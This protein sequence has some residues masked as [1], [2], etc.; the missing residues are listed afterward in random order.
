MSSGAAIDSVNRRTMSPVVAD[1]GWRDDLHESE[2]RRSA[3]SSSASRA[4]ASSTSASA[5]AGPSRGCAR[6]APTT[7]ASTTCPR[8]SP[9]AAAFS[10]RPVRAG[11]CA[12]HAA[13]RRRVVRPHRLLVQ[14]HLHGR[15]H[16]SPR[17]PA[18]G[19]APARARRHFVFSTSNRND[20]DAG[21]FLWP[22][23]KMTT[24]PVRLAVR[25][26]VSSARGLSP[27]T[28]G[29]S[30]RPRSEPTTTPS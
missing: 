16:R 22:D 24:N 29:G 21:R 11:R 2:L 12:R 18:R 17:H 13:V 25:R 3:P 28:A 9:I 30:S 19:A 20:P 10:R 5:P 4:S 8:W 1:Y 23:L 6:S 26:P 15:S 27:S 14:R 7:S